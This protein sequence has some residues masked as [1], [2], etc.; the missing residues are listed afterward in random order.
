MEYGKE[1]ATFLEK[2]SVESDFFI[3]DSIK[4]RL[5]I[6]LDNSERSK[7]VLTVLIT[8]VVYKYFYP[9]QDVRYHQSNMQN[10]YSGRSFDTKYVTPFL[11]KYEFPSMSESGWL[12]RS[13]EQP[14]P[15][16]LDY[17]GKI[18]PKE[19]AE[20][21]LLILNELEV[22]RYSAEVTLK[23]I[24][25]QLLIQREK[26][27][28]NLVRPTEI[29][30]ANAIYILEKHFSYKYKDGFGASRLP[31]L[32]IYAIYK[33][34]IDEVKRFNSCKLAHLKSHTS[35]DLQ[36]G[37]VGDIEVFDKNNQVFEGI[38][39]KWNRLITKE[40]VQIAFDK[41]R[42][43][44]IQRYYILS[45]LR[46]TASESDAI[47]DIIQKIKILHGCQ[48]IVNGVIDT[49]KYYLRLLQDTSNFVD[50]YVSLVEVDRAI[51]Y[52]HK[53]RWNEIFNEV[54]VGGII[55]GE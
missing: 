37:A 36:S 15:Y 44:K 47:N 41:F 39:V 13:L 19:V 8:S 54:M 49:I 12:T 11:R 5:D 14:Y 20:A 53:I 21:F 28:V 29:T 7:G 34:F 4:S 23:Y 3:E 42:I 43:T 50:K 27:R 22:N 16:I 18:S 9:S 25:K 26:K 55:L 48:V 32:A 30:I 40:T 2:V 35:S 45:N 38:E 1:L 52:E 24:F 51:K 17:K 6:I 10:G 46:L 33:C 31:V